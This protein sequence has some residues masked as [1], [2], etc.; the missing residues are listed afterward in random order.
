MQNSTLNCHLL[1]LFFIY[2]FFES[3]LKM[4]QLRAQMKRFYG[5]LKWQID[6]DTPVAAVVLYTKYAFEL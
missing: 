6:E 2:L 5:F 1:E 3:S 4:G